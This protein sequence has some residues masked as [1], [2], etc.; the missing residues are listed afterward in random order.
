MKYFAKLMKTILIRVFSFTLSF[1]F[2]L[3]VF[4]FLKVL[5]EEP[6]TYIVNAQIFARDKFT[7]KCPDLPRPNPLFLQVSIDKN[8]NLKLNKDEMGNLDNTSNLEKVLRRIF[9]QRTRDEVLNDDFQ[10]E[11]FVEIH[12]DNSAKYGNIVKL[13]EV[14]NRTGANPVVLDP[15]E[16][17]CRGGGS[18]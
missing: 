17:L 6:K 18:N 12:P 3:A 11:K 13:I 1:I 4:S 2:G 8:S 10:I 7:Q 15:S 16:E 14:L 9:E 5:I